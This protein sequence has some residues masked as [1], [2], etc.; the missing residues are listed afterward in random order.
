M[1]E[2]ISLNVTGMK[3]GGCETTVKTKLSEMAG[4]ISVEAN[5][6]ENNVTVELDQ[7]VTDIS[8]LS[9]AITEAGFTVE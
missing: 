1:A 2:S 9:N 6:K 5:C 8:S 7:S 3:C 4:V